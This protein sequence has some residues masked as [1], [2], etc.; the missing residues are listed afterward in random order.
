L[1]I[2]FF[3]DNLIPN[4]IILNQIENTSSINL[5]L[6]PLQRTYLQ[7]QYQNDPVILVVLQVIAT[8]GGVFTV[9]SGVFAVIFGRSLMAIIAG[10]YL[11]LYPALLYINHIQLPLG[12]RELSPFGMVGV[13]LKKKLKEAISMR[14]PLL[15]SELNRGGMADFLKEV[16]VD[17]DLIDDPHLSGNNSS[18]KWMLDSMV[19]IEDIPLLH[20]RQH[21]NNTTSTHINKTEL[22]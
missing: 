17:V 19:P 2:T 8:L 1:L 9:V 20:R 22:V 7:T 15:K 6:D 3:I 16:A 12:G 5:I 10:K 11:Y 18:E 13:L 4:T 21:S 14:F